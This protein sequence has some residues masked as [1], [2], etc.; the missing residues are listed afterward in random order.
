MERRYVNPKRLIVDPNRIRREL[1][2]LENM[3]GISCQDLVGNYNFG[4][5]MWARKFLKDDSDVGL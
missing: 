3:D 1:Q 2:E 5:L 4:L